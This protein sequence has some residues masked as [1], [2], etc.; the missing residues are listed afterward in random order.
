MLGKMACMLNVLGVVILTAIT[1]LILKSGILEDGILEDVRDYR[2]LASNRG[3]P[4]CQHP[5][6][7]KQRQTSDT[8]EWINGGEAPQWWNL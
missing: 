4:H 5:L 7:G 2:R 3:F 6:W 1:E 8:G